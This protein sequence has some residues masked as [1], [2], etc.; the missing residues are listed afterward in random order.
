MS[1]LHTAAIYV[2]SY[3]YVSQAYTKNFGDKFKLISAT[4]PTKTGGVDT[5]VYEYV[6]ETELGSKYEKVHFVSTFAASAGV[7]VCLYVCGGGVGGEERE[8]RERERERERE[9]GV[10]S[11]SSTIYY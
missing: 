3:C 7:C 4:G 8:S 5:Y 11:T 10:C 1:G 2:S 6:V 9:R